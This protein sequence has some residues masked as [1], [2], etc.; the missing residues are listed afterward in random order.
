M[1]A[2]EEA[3]G[4]Y[5][6][7]AAI[8]ERLVIIAPQYAEFQRFLSL[9]KD[10]IQELE[11][12]PILIL[13]YQIQQTQDTSQIYAY[14]AAL[15]D[16]LRSRV[17]QQPRYVEDLSQSLNSQAW[18]GLFLGK[19]ATVEAL[20][21]EALALP[22]KNIYLPTNLA[23]ALL[24]QG[25]KKQALKVYTSYRDKPFEVGS[26]K[27]Y[28]DAFLDDM[29]AFEQAGIIPEAYKADVEEV[30]QLLSHP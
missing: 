3:E 9:I 23:P 11:D 15:V 19:F 17:S 18:Y 28:A 27:L 8:W 4:Y 1:G 26:Y 5:K 16:T 29:K 30:K 7:A 25:E 22:Y 24:F 14:Y 12:L 10:R 2:Y 6:Q 20:I 13:Q 21:Q